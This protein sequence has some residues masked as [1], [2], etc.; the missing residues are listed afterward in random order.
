VKAADGVMN[1][2]L[3]HVAD[4]FPAVQ[5]DARLDWVSKSWE[6]YALFFWRYLHMRIHSPLEKVWWS[7]P[8]SEKI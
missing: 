7:Y 2:E 5:R 8:S 1:A 4:F 6:Q 3:R